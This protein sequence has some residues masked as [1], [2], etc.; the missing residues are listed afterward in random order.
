[1]EPQT[2]SSQQ[3]ARK[4]TELM[5]RLEDADRKD[6]ERDF[7]DTSYTDGSRQPLAKYYEISRGSFDH[8][9]DHV[10]AR[11]PGKSVL[12]Y[13]CG[14]S[15]SVIRLENL[16]AGKVVGIDLSP[17]S[18]E[19]ANERASAAGLS[20][21]SFLVM[22]AERLDFSDGSFDVVFGSAVLHHLDL[23]NALSEIARVLKPDGSA[24]F[25]EP[26]GVNPAIRLFRRMTPAL[27]TRDEH[28]LTV[29]DLH[30]I[31]E[32]FDHVTYD[33][34]HLLSVGAVPFR[35]TRAF[36]RIL[37]SLSRVDR[38]AFRYLPPIR[39]LAWQVVMTLERPKNASLG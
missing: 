6:F 7:F 18:I 20:E 38:V 16:G 37:R 39:P 35:R 17:V 15:P 1:M 29:A 36:P 14:S 31:R 4:E 19:R 8:V 25:L 13:G 26:L 24:I 34:H 23:R 28:P 21:Y 22:D 3:Q 5:Q 32:Y 30:L 27:R 11:S 2:E 10:R 9:L 12:E 33:F